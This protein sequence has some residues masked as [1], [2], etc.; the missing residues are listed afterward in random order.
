MLLKD[1]FVD[2]FILFYLFLLFFFV[3][4]YLKYAQRRNSELER[5]VS[6]MRQ[7]QKLLMVL[8]GI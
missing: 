4:N 2:N 5:Q 1:Y 6:P 7:S 3:E 8:P